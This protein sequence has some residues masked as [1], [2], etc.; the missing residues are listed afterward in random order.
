[1]ELSVLG[2]KDVTQGVQHNYQTMAGRQ[3]TGSVETR[4]VLQPRGL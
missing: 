1:M 4:L 3:V 2:A